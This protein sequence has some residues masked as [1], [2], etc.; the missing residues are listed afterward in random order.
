MMKKFINE[1]N[2]VELFIKYPTYNQL[3][4]KLIPLIH[5]GVKK[6]PLVFT[7]MERQIM[8][9]FYWLSNFHLAYINN[10]TLDQIDKGIDLFI[11]HIN[12]PADL[13]D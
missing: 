9:N 2:L 3:K 8:S 13:R 6:Y 7:N 11:K 4:N 12:F 5:K 1:E 10:A